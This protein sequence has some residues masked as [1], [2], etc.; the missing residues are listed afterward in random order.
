VEFWR[1]I[2]DCDG[3]HGD[4]YIRW[5]PLVHGDAH[6]ERSSISEQYSQSACNLQQAKLLLI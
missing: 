4:S 1:R 5:P 2:G 6:R 3:T